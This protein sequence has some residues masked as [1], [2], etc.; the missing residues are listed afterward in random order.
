MK[1]R[2]CKVIPHL[3]LITFSLAIAL[4]LLWVLRV[5]LTDRL[6][7]Y[8]I[9]PEIGVITFENYLTVFEAFPFALWYG[10]SALVAFLSTA[11]S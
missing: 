10:N 3:V 1:R 2:L 11:I 4:P 6:T 8:K 5:S 7:A 9:P